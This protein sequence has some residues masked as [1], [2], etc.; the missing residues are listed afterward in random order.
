MDTAKL[1]K[2]GNS[3]AVRLPREFKFSGDEVYIKKVG[4]NVILSPKDDPWSSFVESLSMFSEDFMDQR[5]EPGLE[6]RESL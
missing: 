3:Q 5:F 1:F 6:M 2:N 4:R